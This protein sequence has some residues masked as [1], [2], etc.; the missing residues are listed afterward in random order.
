MKDKIISTFSSNLKAILNDIVINNKKIFV[1]LK[2]NSAEEAK[3]L[4]I[5]KLECEKKISDLNYFDEINVTFTLKAKDPYKIIAVSSCKGGV[6]KSTVSVNLSLALRKLGKNVGLIDADIYGPS[7]PKLLNLNAKP[8]VNQNKKIIP[9]EAFGIKAISIGFLIDKDKPLIWR[10]PMLQSAIMQLI[11]EVYWNDIDYLVIDLPPGTGDTHLT[12]MQKIHI[13]HAIIV[14]TPQELAL[15]DTRKGINMFKKFNVSISGVIENMSYFICEKCDEKHYLF[16]QGGGKRL[17]KEFNIP[18]LEEIPYD[19]SILEGADK[20]NPKIIN[21][22]SNLN[23]LYI[24]IA[25]KVIK[26]SAF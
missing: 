13:D 17:S 4:E 19:K 3:K 18:F 8:E 16:G 7:I 2:S 14:T 23:N 1:T 22:N 21:E 25:S 15:S 12:I 6:G 9:L 10:G 20:G 26:K 11:N 24:N 5:F